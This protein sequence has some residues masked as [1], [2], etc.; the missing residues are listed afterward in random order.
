V[1]DSAIGSKEGRREVSRY[2]EGER[3]GMTSCCKGNIAEWD[4]LDGPV[5]VIVNVNFA[6]EDKLESK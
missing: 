6:L 5:K 1:V 4:D 3:E 2:V